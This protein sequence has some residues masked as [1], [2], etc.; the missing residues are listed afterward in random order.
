MRLRLIE[1]C[2]AGLLFTCA[3][4]V[5][6]QSDSCKP[7][8]AMLEP[9]GKPT[10]Q[11]ATRHEKALRFL[12]VTKE[13]NVRLGVMNA[14]LAALKSKQE[15]VDLDAWVRRADPLC[16]GLWDRAHEETMLSGA[17]SES[18][19]KADLKTEM[20]IEEQLL[21]LYTKLVIRWEPDAVYKPED[22]Q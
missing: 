1:V 4:K 12:N 11:A 22:E 5:W 10:F 17:F 9:S 7:L 6:A 19:T 2:F 13:Y 21:N 16:D 20:R 14:K 3:M 8:L 15:F 18:A